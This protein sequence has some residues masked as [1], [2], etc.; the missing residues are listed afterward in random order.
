MKE[1]S[2]NTLSALSARPGRLNPRIQGFEVGVNC[3]AA[4]IM[5]LAG[6]NSAQGMSLPQ[7]GHFGS[8]G[9]ATDADWRTK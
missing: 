5:A 9:A 4:A 1:S 2:S 6:K 8:A 3:A 7:R